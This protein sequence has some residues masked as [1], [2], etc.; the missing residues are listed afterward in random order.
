MKIITSIM[1]TLA[2][3]IGSCSA[4]YGA[5]SSTNA[6]A[7]Q[8]KKAA[9]LRKQKLRIQNQRKKKIQ[10]IRNERLRIQN[11]RKKRNERLRIQNERNKKNRK[12]QVRKDKKNKVKTV[13]VFS[14]AS[15]GSSKQSTGPACGRPTTVN[16]P[17]P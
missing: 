1:L 2:L 7:Q 14:C 9:E 3:T 4:V 5:P 12:P 16:R 10:R 11:E 13:P 15:S 8:I 17:K 6:Q